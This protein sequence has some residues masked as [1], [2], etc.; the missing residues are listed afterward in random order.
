MPMEA[1]R[2]VFVT[3]RLRSFPFYAEATLMLFDAPFRRTH[4]HIHTRTL[5]RTHSHTKQ[6][7]GDSHLQRGA[8][9]GG[10]GGCCRSAADSDG[11]SSFPS[12]P[13]GAD[14][15]T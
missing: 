9:G 1:L 3:R 4:T 6:L 5:T 2:G 10:G 7:D 14:F 15:S 13:T 12:F 8:G 11:V